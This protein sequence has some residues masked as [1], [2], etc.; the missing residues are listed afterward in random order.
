MA[1]VIIETP[2]AT[3][4]DRALM[5][6]LPADALAKTLATVYRDGAK[7]VV[8]IDDGRTFFSLKN[9]ETAIETNGSDLSVLLAYH[10][11]NLSQDDLAAIERARKV[12]AYIREA[13]EA[14]R[15]ASRPD[16]PFAKIPAGWIIEEK[17]TI[18]TRT[19]TRIGGDWYTIG[20]KAAQRLWDHAAPKWAG[21]VRNLEHMT[22]RASGYNNSVNVYETYI[23]VGCQRVER[24]ELE[25]LALSQGWD[26]PKGP[27]AE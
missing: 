21:V 26:F 15:E 6:K 27:A 25:Q 18:N 23:Q 10:E 17:L 7:P 11:I 2:T 12:Q 1:D 3:L 13:V 20:A 24:Y 5:V 4:I 8:F 9:L 22:L 14:K 16:Y 19:I